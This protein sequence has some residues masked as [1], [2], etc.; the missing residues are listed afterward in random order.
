VPTFDRY[1]ARELFVPF[2]GATLFVSQLLLATQLFSEAEVL[3]GAGISAADVATVAAALMPSL[4]GFILPIAFLLGTVLGLGRLAEDR[5]VVALGAAGVSPARLLR[6]PLVGALAV[7]ALGLALARWVEPAAAALVRARVAAIVERKLRNDVRPGVFYDQLPGYTLYAERVRNGRWENVLISDLSSPATPVLALAT[8]GVLE[9][10]EGGREMR[11]RL[12]DGQLHSGSGA[13]AP[14]EYVT[15]EFERA[16]APM[17]VA[18][19]LERTTGL[20]RSARGVSFADAP[21]RSREERRRGDESGARRTEAYYHRRISQALATVPFALLAV[22]LGSSRRV[23]RGLAL[24]VVVLAVVVHYLLLRGGE[25][26]A[27]GGALPAWA[28]LQIPTVVLSAAGLAL[29]VL[30]AR[31]GLLAAS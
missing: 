16:S 8:R 17:T 9:P 30:Q 6:V 29:C 31:R 4:L 5:E 12:E 25:V 18:E 10:A 7:A 22:P 15:V 24:T 11:L 19:S 26:L 21:T 1:I 20:S 3:L 27:Q 14:A 28:A 23:R 2:A 13:A